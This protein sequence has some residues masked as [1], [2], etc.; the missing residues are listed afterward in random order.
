MDDLHDE[1]IVNTD[2][3]VEDEKLFYDEVVKEDY[4]LLIV[5]SILREVFGS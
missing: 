3:E 1:S 2:D 4:D 5:D